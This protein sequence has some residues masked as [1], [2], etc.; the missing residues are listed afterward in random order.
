MT[1]FLSRLMTPPEHAERDSLLGGQSLYIA[2]LVRARS[3]LAPWR[4]V[5][6]ADGL[7]MER[8]VL[9]RTN[10]VALLAEHGFDD[11]VQRK[12]E[13]VAGW[14]EQQRIDVG[15]NSGSEHFFDQLPQNVL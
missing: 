6:G 13:Q 4:I 12:A 15:V 14:L 8:G 11:T 5:R 3:L 9:G 7:T 1:S 2:E 10:G